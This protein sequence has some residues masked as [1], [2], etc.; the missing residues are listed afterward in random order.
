MV[1]LKIGDIVIIWPYCDPGGKL[2]RVIDYKEAIPEDAWIIEY[3]DGPDSF[4]RTMVAHPYDDTEIRVFGKFEDIN[5]DTIRILYGY[6][7]SYDR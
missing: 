6:K 2:G 7:G 1:D 3:I 4:K 5:L